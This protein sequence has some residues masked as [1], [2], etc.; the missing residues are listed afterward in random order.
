MSSVKPDD[1]YPQDRETLVKY[2]DSAIDALVVL[3]DALHKKTHL[4]L[5]HLE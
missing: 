1:G 3:S 4:H 5:K 2:L